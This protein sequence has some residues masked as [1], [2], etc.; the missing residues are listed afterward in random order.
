MNPGD[1]FSQGQF[2]NSLTDLGKKEIKEKKTKEEI[3]ND[4]LIA[5]YW[6]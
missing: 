2:D 6:G 3:L 5:T 4:H 1:R